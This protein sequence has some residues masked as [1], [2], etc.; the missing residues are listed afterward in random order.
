MN[1]EDQALLSEEDQYV[2]ELAEAEALKPEHR[3]RK[4]PEATPAPAPAAAPAPA[5]SEAPAAQDESDDDAAPTPTPAPAAAPAPA[6]APAELF[7][8]FNALP[9]ETKKQVRAAYDAR[10]AAEQRAAELDRQY[11]QLHGKTAPLQSAQSKLL[12]EHTRLQQEVQKL[13]AAST[14]DTGKALRTR[15]A[16]IRKQF[17]E[18]ADMFEA[19]L[20]EAASARDAANKIREEFEGRISRIDGRMRL[21]DEIA[22]VAA[23][24]PDMG[25]LKTAFD[26]PSGQFVPKTD[27]QEARDLCLWANSLDPVDREIIHPRLYSTKAADVIYALNRFKQD[28]AWAEAVRAQADPGNAQP[29]NAAPQK[30]ALPE[31]DP[32][33]KRRASPPAH[34]P[35]RNDTSTDEQE[36]LSGVELWRERQKQ[37]ARQRS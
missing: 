5:P 14:T 19:V 36:Y 17:P 8:G 35:S 9:E 27:T 22:Q 20:N 28:R 7:P 16:E 34:T 18:D 23:A 33:P 13:R 1:T 32:D 25:K 12:A 24:H 30:P 6:P 26:T 21:N 37:K 31:V 2:A 10:A 4:P 15:I 11:K 3:R 29:G